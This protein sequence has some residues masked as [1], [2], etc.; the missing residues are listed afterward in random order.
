MLTLYEFKQF[1]SS[2]DDDDEDDENGLATLVIDGGDEAAT[3]AAAVAANAQNAARDL[4]NLPSNV[5]TPTFLAERAEELAQGPRLPHA[6]G[7]R[8]QGDR[9]REDGRLRRGRQGHPH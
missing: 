4:Q 6:R 8:S 5:A 9:G 2:G 1:K 3:E 7:A